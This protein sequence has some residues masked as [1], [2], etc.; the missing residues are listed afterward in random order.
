[1]CYHSIN[2]PQYLCGIYT[3]ITSVSFCLKQFFKEVFMNKDTFEGK[4][5]EV[6]GEIRKQWGKL[7]DNDITE[8]K[9]RKEEFLGKLQSKYGWTKEKAETEFT[10]WWDRLSAKNS[11]HGQAGNEGREHAAQVASSKGSSKNEQN[12][13]HG[14]APQQSSK[15]NAT[16]G[17]NYDA[18]KTAQGQN[19][20]RDFSNPSKTANPS[21]DASR[22]GS[23]DQ[24]PGAGGFDKSKKHH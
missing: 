2:T 24:Q 1:L 5:H 12:A 20:P 13:G 17:G 8:M 3:R 23:S 6:K 10:S 14:S 21:R 19:A 9:G 18:S 7:T 11:Q 22:P 15:G 4:W 16:H